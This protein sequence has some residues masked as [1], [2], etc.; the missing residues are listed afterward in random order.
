MPKR[1]F[2][3]LMAASYT[4]HPDCVL[5]M[6]ATVAP[7]GDIW[8]R[9]LMTPTKAAFW[10]FQKWL[11]P[12]VHGRRLWNRNADG[13]TASLRYMDGRGCAVRD[14]KYVA[15][16]V[17]T[18]TKCNSG[19]VIHEA[20][21]AAIEYARRAPSNLWYGGA[22]VE[23]ENSRFEEQTAYALSRISW[24]MLDRL[25]TLGYLEKE[26]TMPLLPGKKNIGKNITTEVAA[27][28]PMAQAKA[29]ALRVA[30]VPKAKKKR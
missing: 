19:L 5:D 12:R 23:D 4:R 29:I 30:G 21:H 14:P 24:W 9:V 13:F 7:R 20:L 16:I 1:R 17:L 10:R 25:K 8:V 26:L 28:K 6:A 15:F 18:A 27:G 11:L 3:Q 22:A 2:K